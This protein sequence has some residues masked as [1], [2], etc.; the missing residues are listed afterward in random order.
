[1]TLS[2]TQTA[3]TL[4]VMRV[5][6]AVEIGIV[7]VACACAHTSRL[8]PSTWRDFTAPATGVAFRAPADYQPRN[9]S[10]CWH[11]AP[12]RWQQTGWRDFCVDAVDSGGWVYS[13][14]SPGNGK[15]IADCV[16][17]N[18]LHVDTLVL[19]GR[20][21][22]VERARVSGGIGHIERERDL[23]VRIRLPNGNVLKLD[24]TTAHDAGYHE[25]LAIAATMRELRPER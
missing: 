17:V 3:Y 9:T 18:E 21:T 2:R 7:S 5:R 12:E 14:S 11:R 6:K 13:F 24:G 16:T 25:L 10:G 22:I 4:T 8:E 15:C 23:L 19:G 1:M 20:R